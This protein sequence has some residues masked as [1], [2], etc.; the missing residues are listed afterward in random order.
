MGTW[1]LDNK[2]TNRYDSLDRN[3]D[4]ATLSSWYVFSSLRFYPLAGTDTYQL[5]AP[6]FESAIIN[7]GDSKLEIQT[8]S[9]SI[10][11]IYVKKI[12]LNGLI[13]DRIWIKHEE[14]A[15]GGILM[16]E[17][18]PDPITRNMH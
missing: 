4:A 11:N 8:K 6:L 5:G 7:L 16:F 10:E 9:Y 18:S 15:N 2:Y 14:I 12:T 1:I 17:M 13:L 3:E